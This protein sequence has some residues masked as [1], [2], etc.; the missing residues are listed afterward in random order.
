M[1]DKKD[2]GKSNPI[3]VVESTGISDTESLPKVNQNAENKFA[4]VDSA[5][6]NMRLA[7]LNGATGILEEKVD[8]GVKMVLL[9]PMKRRKEKFE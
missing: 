1:G 2:P 6:H 8:F 7:P 9:G 5:N 4:N 3:G